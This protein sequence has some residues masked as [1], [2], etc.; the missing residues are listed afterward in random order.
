[1]QYRLKPSK[2]YTS[3]FNTNNY[4][5][6]FKVEGRDLVYSKW[7]LCLFSS[8]DCAP[9]VADR[10]TQQ[11]PWLCGHHRSAVC[12]WR[13]RFRIGKKN[14]FL[15]CCAGTWLEVR[16]PSCIGAAL[17]KTSKMWTSWNGLTMENI[18]V[19]DVPKNV[20][21]FFEMLLTVCG[22]WTGT[23]KFGGSTS[24][25]RYR[26]SPR[27]GSS[28]LS[29]VCCVCSI[30]FCI[31]LRCGGS[32]ASVSEAKFITYFITRSLLYTL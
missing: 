2:D 16:S 23:N 17:V 3:H 30:F 25:R 21:T 18:C 8:D 5:C 12:G 15:W 27:W 24:C 29:A 26:W 9:V 11:H 31:L 14:F 13:L 6:E 10:H 28:P 32:G 7:G 19:Y 20:W 22:W 4:R 1:M